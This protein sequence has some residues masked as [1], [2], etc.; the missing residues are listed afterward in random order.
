MQARGPLGG[1]SKGLAKKRRRAALTPEDFVADVSANRRSAA[2]AVRAWLQFVSPGAP[3]HFSLF[4]LRGALGERHF[5]GDVIG[6]YCLLAPCLN[7]PL[8]ACTPLA[9]MLHTSMMR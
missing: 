6:A 9:Q 4:C 1:R 5:F 7:G 2:A 8:S 3:I